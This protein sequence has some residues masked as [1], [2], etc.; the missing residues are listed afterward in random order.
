MKMV[1]KINLS[2]FAAFALAM[3]SAS[4]WAQEENFSSQELQDLKQQPQHQEL[5]NL[6]D[7]KPLIMEVDSRGTR[8][9]VPSSSN[10]ENATNGVG[11]QANKQKSDTNKSSVKEKNEEDPL[12]FNFLYFIIQRFKISDIVDD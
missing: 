2:L 10:K 4:L 3:C 9:N 6:G 1:L 11:T 8:A 12:N 7:D 5:Q